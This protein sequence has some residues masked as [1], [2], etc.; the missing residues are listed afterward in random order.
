MQPFLPKENLVVSDHLKGCF[1]TFG[2]I[3]YSWPSHNPKSGNLRD[4]LV[5]DDS[6]RQ[7]TFNVLYHMLHIVLYNRIT[8][9]GF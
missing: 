6:Q 2:V 1:F 7:I 4:D 3:E 5:K 8:V 9:I